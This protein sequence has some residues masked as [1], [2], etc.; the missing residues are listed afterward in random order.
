MNILT[1]LRLAHAGRAFIISLVAITAAFA[2]FSLSANA[3]VIPDEQCVAV[4]DE[5]TLADGIASI[6]TFVHPNWNHSLEGVDG[7]KWIWNAALADQS[8]PETVIFTKTM[9]LVSAPTSATLQIASDNQYA[10]TVNTVAVPA[11]DGTSE[12]NFGAIESCAITLTPG[13]NTIE[14]SVTNAAPGSTS[15]GNPAGLIY[16]IVAEDAACGTP[17]E[18]IENSCVVP[19]GDDSIVEF[20]SSNEKTLQDIVIDE[21]TYDSV[22]VDND[23]TGTQ[24]WMGNNNAADFSVEV[25]DSIAAHTHTFG[26]YLNGDVS[27]F[28]PVFNN[29]GVNALYPAIPEKNPGDTAPFSVPNVANQ[30]TFAIHNGTTGSFYSV[31][32]SDNTDATQHAVV[33]NPADNTYLIAFEDLAGGGDKDFNDLVVALTLTSC[34]QAVSCNAQLNLLDNGGFESPN[35]T[36]SQKWDIFASGSSPLDW[37]AAWT[38]TPANP[39]FEIANVE[40]QTNGI[41]AGW[42]A[43]EGDQWTE[44]DSD[45]DGPTGSISGEKGQVTIY[46]IIPTIPGET[47]TIDFMFSPRPDQLN[48]A[49][50]KVEVLANGTVI[51]SAGPKAGNGA[52]TDWTAHQA[53]FTATSS[54][55]W[56]TVAFRDAGTPNDSF[57]TLIDNAVMTCSLPD[58]TAKLHAT[59]IVCSDEQYLPNWG[60]GAADITAQTA[61]NFLNDVND[62]HDTDV[63]WLEPDWQFEWTTNTLSATNPG[64]NDLG[65]AG[66]PWTTFGPTDGDGTISTNIPAGDQV[67]VR[68]VLQ[69]GY[70]VFSGQ[71]TTE[72][73]SAEIY[74]STDVLNYDNWDYINPVEEGE[75]YYCV[76]FNAPKPISQCNPEKQTILTS[77][78]GQTEDESGI[79]SVVSWLHLSWLQEVGE[80]IWKDSAT[81]A[82]DAADG[83]TET[84]TR[85]FDIVGTPHDSTLTLA[86]DNQY[87]AYVNGNEVC[88]DAGEYNYSA[89][90]D[91]AVPASVLLNG[92]NTLTVVVTN[93]DH[94]DA[95]TPET[96]PAGL[97]YTLTVNE[98]ECEVPEIATVIATKVVCEAEEY[99][100]NMAGGANITAATAQNHVNQSNG[101]CWLQEDWQFQY[102]TPSN[103]DPEDNGYDPLPSPWANFG[104]TNGDG[105]ATLQLP[106]EGVSRIEV[107]EVLQE[108]YVPFTG[109]NNGH[110]SAELYCADDVAGYDNWEW[111]NGP[112]TGTTY[113]CVGF[114]A[115]IEPPT[116]TVALCKFDENQ[117]PLS[118]WTLMLK[119]K[120]METLSVLASDED[121]TDTQV[122]LEEGMSYIA[123]ADGTWLNDRGEENRVDAEYSTITNWSSYMDGYDGFGTDIL[124]L[125]IDDTFGDWGPYTGAHTYAR[126]FVPS[127][128]EATF[129]IYDTY[130]GDNSQDLDVT[131][132]EGYAGITDESGCVT[133]YDVPRGDYVAD[134]LMQNGWEFVEFYGSSYSDQSVLDIFDSNSLDEGDYEEWATPVS[135]EDEEEVFTFVNDDNEEATL[136]I[137]KQ[138][139]GGDETFEFVIDP[140]NGSDEEESI[141]TVGGTGSTTLTLP[142]GDYVLSETVPE[143]W[144]LQTVSCDYGYGYSEGYVVGNDYHLYLEDGETVICTFTNT[145]DGVPTNTS[146]TIVVSGDTSAGENLLGWLFNRDLSTQSPFEFNNDEASIGS[147]SLF[148]E[149]I[150]NTI[151]G[152]SDKFIGEL[153][154]L[155]PLA[156][157]NS[158]SYDFLIGSPDD[159]VPHQFY[160]NV[161]ANFGV[162]DDDKFYDCRYNIVPLVG[163]TGSFTTVTFDPTLAYPVTTHGTSPHGCPASPAG[164]DLLSAG[165]NIRVVAINVGDTAG[166]DTGVS[167]YL[168]NAVTSITT[169]SNTHTTTYDFEPEPETPSGGGGGGGGQAQVYN[170]NGGGGDDDEDGIVAGATTCEALLSTYMRLGLPNNLDEVMKLQ[171][172]LSNEMSVAIPLTGF[173]GPATD[174]AV[175]SFQK[176]YWEDVLQPWF[177]IPDSAIKDADDST[178]Y[179]YKT[180]RWKINDIFCPDSEAYPALP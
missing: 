178:G 144:T 145:K 10:V 125:V 69:D 75:E 52:T 91:C 78:D 121:G 113:H 39:A 173:F 100:P 3:V 72:D 146:E 84:F 159:T 137:V 5:A 68:E 14:I 29:N 4:S 23:Q 104:L 36:T 19:Q 16:R 161:Y 108:G 114:N 103:G 53:S 179:V 154:L 86:V 64:D 73:V 177:G 71:N 20:G 143:G 50:N 63:C 9:S 118:G 151:N 83:T 30:I 28:Y 24:Y 126:S 171:E 109:S 134:E 65:P 175:H 180:T 79:A 174:A 49:Q 81:S 160:M 164:M 89:T 140:E 45:W 150:T 153:F 44:L 172:F 25:L 93:M 57:G 124:E 152:N 67:W 22:D 130:Y 21:T 142:E 115:L 116:S 98:N 54:Q 148:V 167:G 34:G 17:P 26:Y 76:A 58:D 41:I 158:I 56:T 157:V 60:A 82:Q 1:T 31:D 111:I 80:W 6:A 131:I 149:P 156:G 40:I 66:A 35:V 13:V 122:D 147:G 61:Q 43:A 85:T 32:T 136:I 47:Y 105:V 141:T 107:R 101:K 92:E 77:G 88:A 170:P 8:L 18:P 128:H 133:F 139:E 70:T 106:V 155:T 110:V 11:C 123:I 37:F 99:L 55:F 102:A 163:S 165:S 87:V 169:G 138:A 74:C 162:S 120:Y 7:A 97:L 95:N 27:T 15:Q 12:N 59:K 112:Q 2:F 132:Y 42:V 127:N 129:R 119:G 51:G 33:Y 94:Q 117:Q 166:G 168:D 46:Q 135:V 48:A 38:E 176:K 62:G 96:N 90:V